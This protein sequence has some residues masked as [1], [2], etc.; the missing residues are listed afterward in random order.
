M[1]ELRKD[2]VIGRWVII[3]TE[4]RKRP[5]DYPHA[6]DVKKT[7]VP[8]S[9]CPGQEDKTPPEI[10]AYRANGSKPNTPGWW[11][12]VVPNKF[13][14]LKIEGE[15]DR[16][17]DGMYDLMNGV[18]AHEVVIE[19]PDHSKEL[20]DIEDEHVEEVIW[21]YKDRSLDLRND[22]RF[23]YVLI[24]KNK[25]KE[26]GASLEHTHSQIIATPTVPKR[27][28]EEFRGAEEHFRIK[29]R[30]V[31]CDIIRQETKDNIR[32]VCEND[33]MISIAPFAPRFPF[34]TWILPK[35]HNSDFASIEKHEIAGLAKIL[36][37]TLRRM[38]KVLN[39]PP[40]NYII[41]TSECK[42][43]NMPHYHWHIEIIPRIVNHAGFEWG[44]GFYINPT[45][46]EEAAKFMREVEI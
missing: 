37:E 25:G 16:R 21:A 9:F 19:T 22:G 20:S 23:H 15:L 31:F 4:R 44:S 32:I 18:G 5:V 11:V 42:S 30:C 41:H 3:S 2:V 7:S 24:F 46:P 29:E 17:G 34:E 28:I 38:D 43:P 40:Y 10:I 45:P 36:K 39:N 35:E 1:P 13:P 33:T 6:G 8:C 26:A 14:A 27:V 12:R